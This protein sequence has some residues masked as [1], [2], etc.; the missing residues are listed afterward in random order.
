VN[1]AADLGAKLDRFLDLLG[2]EE[3]VLALYGTDDVTPYEPVVRPEGRQC[4]WEFAGD[5][6]RGQTLVISKDNFGCPG[7]GR[8]FL[9]V[10][11]QDRDLA[12]FLYE[13]EG[14]KSSL[15]IAKAWI[16]NMRHHQG[17]KEFAL[18]GLFRPERIAEAATVTFL[19][20]FD[21]LSALITAA[22][23]H[24]SDAL[25]SHVLVLVSSGCGLLDPFQRTSEPM[26]AIGALDMAMRP[27]LPARLAAFTVNIPM[28]YQ[29]VAMDETS[30]LHKPF[31]KEL[32]EVRSSRA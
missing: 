24:S 6:R 11:P 8:Y 31:W 4:C 29:L 23:W 18:V 12:K 5:W 9:G 28:L 14:L 17:A 30:F 1:D 16:Q 25:A 26:A 2:I 3:T 22:E 15:D 7:A 21:Q 32:R 27:H 20:D 13:G 10:E 19:V